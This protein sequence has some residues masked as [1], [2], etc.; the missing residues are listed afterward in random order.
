MIPYRYLALICLVSAVIVSSAAA[1]SFCS[2]VETGSSMWLTSGTITTQMGSRF[3]TASAD[4]GTELFN[5][6][7]VGGYAPG[8]PA[9]GSVSAFIRGRIIED[10]QVTEFDDTTSI[11]GEISAFSKNMVY[12]SKPSCLFC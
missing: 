8:T 4:A 12:A 10:N 11:I 1:E 3:I 5:N 6:V 7:Q 2:R 9:H